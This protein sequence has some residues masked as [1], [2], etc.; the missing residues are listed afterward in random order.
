MRHN[1]VATLARAWE[2]QQQ[3]DKHQRPIAY[4][5][6]SVATGLLTSENAT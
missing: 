3:A 6:A 4:A 5:L 1:N 2:N